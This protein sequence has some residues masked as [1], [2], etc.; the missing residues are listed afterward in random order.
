MKQA[1]AHFREMRSAVPPKERLEVHEAVNAYIST[2]DCAAEHLLRALLGKCDSL[3]E[4]VAALSRQ[5]VCL[6]CPRSPCSAVAW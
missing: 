3:D 1:A 5:Q 2:L 6:V 4:V